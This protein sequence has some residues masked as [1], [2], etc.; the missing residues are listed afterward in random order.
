M[1]LYFGLDD[2][3]ITRYIDVN[4]V[5]DVDDRKSTS[6]NVFSFDGITI[7]WLRNKIMLLSTQW[8]SNIYRAV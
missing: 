7:S 6:G 1:K 8:R 2:L 5:G 3:N 4:F